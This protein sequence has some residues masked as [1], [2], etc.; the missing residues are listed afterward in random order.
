MKSQKCFLVI[1]LLKIFWCDATTSNQKVVAITGYREKFDNGKQQKDLTVHDVENFRF[2]RFQS[3]MTIKKALETLN[4]KSPL[5]W[6]QG[7]DGRKGF[8]S[9]TKLAGDWVL[10]ESQQVAVKCTAE[11]VLQAYLSGDLQEQ[12][13]EK[14]VLECRFHTKTYHN[15]DENSKKSINDDLLLGKYYQQDL[16]LRSQRVITSHTGEMRYSQNLVIDK[17]GNDG[18]SVIV[19]LDP[20]NQKESTKRPFESLSVY[21]GLQQRNDDVDIYAAGVMKVNRKVVPNLVVF[22]ASGIA[23]SMAGKGTLWLAGF[24]DKRTTPQT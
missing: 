22:D 2:E 15:D 1:L 12:W 21:V 16:I 14:E 7:K 17:I 11:E 13:N 19:R 24:F 8:V 3:P 6:F 9:S 5:K 20:K 4:R 23:G 10:A 18:Y